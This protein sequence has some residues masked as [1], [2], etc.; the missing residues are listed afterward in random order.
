MQTILQKGRGV[1][2]EGKSK[3]FFK[4]QLNDAVVRNVSPSVCPCQGLCVT[5]ILLACQTQPNT[6]V[7]GNME[8]QIQSRRYRYI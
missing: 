1:G 2:A 8:S 7:N 3:R 6:P 4:H 5:N